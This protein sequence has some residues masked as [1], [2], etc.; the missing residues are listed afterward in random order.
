MSDIKTVWTHYNTSA[1]SEKFICS[2]CKSVAYYPQSHSRLNKSDNQ[3]RCG[4]KYCP[5][6]GSRVSGVEGVV[7]CKR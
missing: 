5:N 3:P 1:K 7:L 6:C 4:Y 2:S